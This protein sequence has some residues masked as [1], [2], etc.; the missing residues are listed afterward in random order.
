MTYLNIGYPYVYCQSK[1]VMLHYWDLFLLTWVDKL[2]EICLQGLEKKIE[3]YL[4]L[5]IFFFSYINQK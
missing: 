1:L 4:F 5:N 2:F 3:I